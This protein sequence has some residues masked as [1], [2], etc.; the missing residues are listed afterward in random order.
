MAFTY[1]KL[2]EV[3]VGATAV[4]S[5][6]FNNIPQNYNDLML[7][8]SVRSNRASN[9]DN[10]QLKINGSTSN[11]T[12]R[13]ISGNGASAASGTLTVLYIG[14][15]PAATATSSTF[16]NQ[17][18]YIPNY[19]GS[20]NKSLTIDSVAE[21]NATTAYVYLSA[22]LWSSVTTISSLSIFSGNGDSFVQYSP[23]TLYGVKAEV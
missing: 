6:D 17:E 19:A 21:N 2:A 7:K 3:T 12:N 20:T 5:I 8:I 4:A 15:V 22:N 13:Y 16:G 11:I 1:S 18:I 9:W 14:D 23:A 10:S